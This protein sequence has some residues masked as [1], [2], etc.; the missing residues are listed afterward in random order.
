MVSKGISKEDYQE[1]QKNKDEQDF[2]YQTNERLRTL[3][4]CIEQER[5]FCKELDAHIGNVQVDFINRLDNSFNKYTDIIKNQNKTID[6]LEK[7]IK[8]Q[9]KQLNEFK[10]ILESNQSNLITISKII[11]NI[12][13]SIDDL[14]RK[15]DA[16][17]Q[18]IYG[19]FERQNKIIDQKIKDHK[20]E[21][22]N[23]PSEIPEL[24]KSIDQKIEL[25]ELNGQNA[26]L[27]SSNNERQ[28]MLIEKKIENL[29]QLIK[30]I[31]LTKKES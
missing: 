19:Q 26:V 14:T 5:E 1:F 9:D 25:A 30:S 7:S 8:I 13:N 27:R 10:N 11:D 12:L 4:F 20:Q 29:Y 18:D 31:D 3:D 2:V 21:I 22:L 17:H 24:K 6:I 28:I 15:Y 23:K 16:M